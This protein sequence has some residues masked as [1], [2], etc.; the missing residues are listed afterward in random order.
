MAISGD[1]TTTVTFPV[2][3]GTGTLPAG[4]IAPGQYIPVP[5]ATNV[6]LQVDPMVLTALIRIAAA[7]EGIL[8]KMGSGFE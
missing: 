1:Y 7:L 8:E 5:P 2:S 3:P 6:N 4:G